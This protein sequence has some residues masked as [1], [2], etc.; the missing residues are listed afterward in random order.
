MKVCVCLSILESIIKNNIQFDDFKYHRLQS[1]DEGN[2]LRGKF[3][4]ET[5][6]IYIYVYILSVNV[7]L[8]I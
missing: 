2:G 4:I 7:G 3:S 8:G 1:M 5:G 6:T